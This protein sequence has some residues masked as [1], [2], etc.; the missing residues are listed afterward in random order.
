MEQI[1]LQAD[2]REIIGKKVRQLRRQGITP[3]HLF[4][5]GIDSLALQCNTIQLHN[6]LRRAGTTN[7]IDLKLDKAKKPRKVVV[8]EV[9]H[10]PVNGQL[11]HVDFYEV[12]MAD[13]IKV[14]VPLVYVGE[15]PA[16]KMKGHVLLREATS[17][18][19]E[20]LPENMPQSIEIDLSSLMDTGQAIHVKDVVPPKGVTMVSDPDTVLVMIDTIRA[21]KAEAEIKEEVVK[22][23][24]GSQHA[25]A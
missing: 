2:S 6:A 1:E 4:G 12:R 7:L 13:K 20:C 19:I 25:E 14:E 5:H 8:R 17:L 21:E 11:L 15:A 3:V 10:H 23:T 22:E 9:R 24:E 16:L 18:H